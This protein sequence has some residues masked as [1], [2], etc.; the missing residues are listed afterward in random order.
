M[1]KKRF[2]AER[3]SNGLREVEGFDANGPGS[4]GRRFIFVCCYLGGNL[5]CPTSGSRSE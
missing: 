4:P 2:V 3:I 5:L 1:S